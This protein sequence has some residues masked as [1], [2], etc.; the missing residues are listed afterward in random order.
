MFL[1]GFLAFYFWWRFGLYV[2]RTRDS[3]GQ[4]EWTQEFEAIES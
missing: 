2:G 1:N 4:G 3:Y